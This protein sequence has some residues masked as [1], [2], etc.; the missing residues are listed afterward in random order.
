MNLLLLQR[1][2]YY[3][4]L[5]F[6][7]EASTCQNF[8]PVEVIHKVMAACKDRVGVDSYVVASIVHNSVA[9]DDVGSFER[10]AASTVAASVETVEAD[11]EVYAI[12][13]VAL[14]ERFSVDAVATET[15][16][17]CPKK[18]KS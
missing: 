10:L 5:S 17:R 6:P 15:Q 16:I 9:S 18:V 13:F 3:D 11:S 8:L 14:V 1:V 12:E 2:I 7:S 4:S